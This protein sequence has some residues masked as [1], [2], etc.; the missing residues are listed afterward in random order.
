MQK[1]HQNIAIREENLVKHMNLYI[2]VE[3][4]HKHNH[5]V[6]VLAGHI[7]IPIAMCVMYI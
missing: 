6:M 5:F 4:W 7:V 3:E 2:P 1:S